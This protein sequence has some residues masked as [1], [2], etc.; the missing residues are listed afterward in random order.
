[1]NLERIG[2]KNTALLMIDIQEK[3]L[4]T[5][6]E[7]EALIR[8]A[9]ILLELSKAYDIPTITTEQYPKGLGST[10]EEL[11]AYVISED[12]YDKMT[13]SAFPHVK[14]RLEKSGIKT[15]IV[16]GME[17]HVCVYQTIRDLIREGY[18]VIVPLDA[19]SS[20]TLQNKNVGLDLIKSMGASVTCTETLVF[21][22]LEDAEAQNFR[23]FSKL[24]R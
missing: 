18:E 11:S 9:K 13:F 14:K 8:N 3:L 10:I 4:P 20:R 6:Y 19:V 2:K 5:M 1:M 7:K 15:V 16:I 24:I 17:T 22:M 23:Y 12:L 21:D